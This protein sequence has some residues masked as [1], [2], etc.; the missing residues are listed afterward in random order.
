M[1]RRSSSRLWGST[2]VS[3]AGTMRGPWGPLCW[4]RLPAPSPEKETHYR[5]VGL[6]LASRRPYRVCVKCVV[7]RC[8][9]SYRCN[10]DSVFNYT[11]WFAVYPPPIFFFYGWD[12]S[13]FTELYSPPTQPLGQNHTHTHRDAYKS[14]Q[15]GSLS[16]PNAET[17]RRMIRA[18]LFQQVFS[19]SK[20]KASFS[21]VCVCVNANSYFLLQYIKKKHA[22][23]IP[24]SSIATK[25]SPSVLVH[26][27]SGL[28]FTHFSSK[29]RQRNERKTKEK[30]RKS[31]HYSA[32]AF[33]ER[34]RTEVWGRGWLSSCVLKDEKATASSLQQPSTSR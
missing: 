9:M 32:A 24:I 11:C 15:P 13:T 29:R 19:L 31:T 10:S 34:D 28:T 27:K 21:L 26:L 1:E 18:K 14:I 3:N 17:V 25:K 8:P 12:K 20:K 22:E 4:L 7:W 30:Q 16:M 2:D 33:L 23:L 6:Y 5:L